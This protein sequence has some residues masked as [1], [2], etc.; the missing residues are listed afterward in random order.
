VIDR[1]GEETNFSFHQVKLAPPRGHVGPQEGAA[2]VQLL[3]REGIHTPHH[4]T[5]YVTK[6]FRREQ[7][8][9]EKVPLFAIHA[10]VTIKRN[11]LR[12]NS[13]GLQEAMR[14]E[15]EGIVDK[16][17]WALTVSSEVP[18]GANVLSG[19]FLLLPSRT[20]APRSTRLD[21]LHKAIE[22]SWVKV[23]V[24]SEA[25]LFIPKDSFH[26][27]LLIAIVLALTRMDLVVATGRGL[28]QC[29]PYT[30]Y[31]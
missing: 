30:T 21:T 28:A 10:S 8:I 17:T 24:L 2:S 31:E 27:L 4:S 25:C 16:G 14:R 29:G 19:R 5:H 23:G 12:N 7:H 1:L 6:K 20:S 22:E 15:I 9:E 26:P 11:D 18:T 3:N 13:P